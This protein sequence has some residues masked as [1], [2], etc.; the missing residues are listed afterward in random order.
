MSGQVSDTASKNQRVR[1]VAMYSAVAGVAG[2]SLVAGADRAEARVVRWTPTGGFPVV[3]DMASDPYYI[4]LNKV[5][6]DDFHIYPHRAYG[7][8]FSLW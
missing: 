3:I 4:D 6:F 7:G 5:G 8:G 2:V 1:K